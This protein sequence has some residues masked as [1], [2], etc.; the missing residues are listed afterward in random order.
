MDQRE[1]FDSLRVSLEGFEGTD[2]RTTPFPNQFDVPGGLQPGLGGYHAWQ[3]RYLVHWVHHGPVTES[4]SRWVTSA[5]YVDDRLY[6]YYDYPNDQD[7]HL[8]ID[9][10]LYDGKPGTD[11]GIALRDPS[12]GSD[13][14]VIRDLEGR[15]HLIFEDW[16][17]IN[18]SQRSWDSPLAGHAVSP[19]GIGGWEILDPA[20]DH[21]TTPTDKSATYKHPH[22]LQ[23]PDWDTNIAEYQVHMPKQNAYGDWALISVGGQYYLFGD[24]DLADGHKMSVG[25]FTSPTLAEE[26]TWCGHV[27]EGHPDPDIGF[28]EG[29]F[30]LITQQAIDWSSSGPWVGRVEARV[31]VDRDGDGKVNS[32]TEWNEVK[33]SYDYMHGF[34]RQIH[35]APTS[36]DLS[37]L[38][39]GVGFRFECRLTDISENASKGVVERILMR[40]E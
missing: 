6:L 8:Y 29:R 4:Y 20:V 2:L 12:H 30:Y 32:W 7:P 18:A 17:P 25:W 21:R 27:G 37:E 23:H 34:A 38:P 35:K 24:Y 13:S 15:F 22:W 36:L 19:D 10:N 3:S 14:G 5:E 11:M 33:E 9:E 26:F 40:F 1:D 31:G 39:A 16:S 28:A